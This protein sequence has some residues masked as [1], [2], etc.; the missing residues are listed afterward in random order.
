M[1]RP[2]RPRPSAWALASS[3]VIFSSAPV[4]TM[5][6]PA[7]AVSVLGLATGWMSQLGDEIGDL[8]AVVVLGEEPGQR[9]GRHRTDAVDGGQVQIV[10]ARRA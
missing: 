2:L 1:R 3:R 4:K 10:V 8:G 5:V 6:L 9:L 7:T